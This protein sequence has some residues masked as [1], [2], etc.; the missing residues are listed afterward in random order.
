[1]SLQKAYKYIDDI[2][3]NRIPAC[4]YVKLAVR[5]H[6]SDLKRNDI[7]IDEQAASRVFKF[8][9]FV[10]LV[11]G[12]MAGKRFDPTPEQSFV[13]LS[14]F[15]WKRKETG[16]RRF[17]V[18]DLEVARKWGKMIALD[19][20]IPTPDGFTTMCEL[21]EGQ[22]IFGG[23]GK[24]CRV[25]RKSEVDYAPESYL[26]TFSNGQQVKACAEHQW[27]LSDYGEK[28]IFTTKELY[29]G[30]MFPLWIEC[31]DSTL[32][33]IGKYENV[34]GFKFIT[35]TSIVPCDPVPMQCIEVDSS[36]NTYLIGET[37]VRTHNTTF[38]AAIGLYGLVGDGENRGQVYSGGTTRDQAAICFDIAK[39][40]AENTPELAER[41]TILTRNMS[42]E[43]SASFFRYMASDTK[44]LDGFNPHIA[45]LD[46]V[47]AYKTNGMY[48]IFKSGMVARPNPL[49]FMITTAGF[50]KEWW[51]YKTQRKHL[52]RVLK[53]EA[54]DDSLFGMIWTLDEGD[55]WQDERVWPKAIP[56]IG[57]N[58][59]Y[60]AI[61]ERVQ[62]AINKPSDR[63][64]ILTKQF[65]IW[66]DGV[67]TWIPK[68]KWRKLYIPE[69]DL[70]DKM[71]YGGVDLSYVMDI[72][73]YTL[74]FNLGD[75]RRYLKHKFFVP[76]D[77]A[78]QRQESTGIPYMDWIQEGYLISNEGNT[79]DY[80]VVK[81][82]II[83]DFYQYD[84]KTIGFDK[85]NANHIMQEINDVIPRR[86]MYYNERWVDVDAV[87]GISP[88]IKT[89]SPP[90]KE[91]ERMIF[92]KVPEICHDG[93]PVMEWM[94]GNVAIKS[95]PEGDIRPDKDKSEE[96]IDGV[97]SSILSIEQQLFWDVPQNNTKSRYEEDGL[98][99]I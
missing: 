40:M 18:V 91:F 56:S 34:Y 31:A 88:H 74:N 73:A 66:T 14:V 96:K 76:Y 59:S 93:N 67:K 81:K 24:K 52:L 25:V 77:T 32:K 58:I 94:I 12:E 8:F 89:I 68:E 49:I 37:F 6:L 20:L 99:I 21:K 97:M 63:N 55:D 62:E 29:N 85:A 30:V 46:E 38:L 82:H 80:N 83:D 90:T 28:K 64:E 42:H 86:Q 60:D 33:K 15:G 54:T 84:I 71:A 48:E 72:T 61:R 35:I 27:Q 36:D 23:D 41:L 50:F 69:P 7:Y 13:I 22:V 3:N 44:K 57:Y 11:E 70:K 10:T 95:N 53:G 75:G 16:K 47:H 65:N 19:T 4:E 1:M 5:R 51:Y 92:A 26:M 45:I 17:T 87:Y 79:I 98:V 78:R 2:T 9:S 43:Q 39:L